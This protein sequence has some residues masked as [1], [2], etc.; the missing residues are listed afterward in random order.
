MAKRYR[1]RNR[2][3]EQTDLK[4]DYQRAL[5]SLT[6]KQRQA[7]ELVVEQEFTVTETMLLLRLSEDA[8]RD[9]LERARIVVSDRMNDYRPPAYEHLSPPPPD[10]RWIQP[11]PDDSFSLAPRCAV[12]GGNLRTARQWVCVTCRRKYGL[13]QRDIFLPPWAAALVLD[14]RNRRNSGLLKNQELVMADLS[15]AE[16]AEAVESGFESGG[17]LD[18]SDTWF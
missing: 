9:R 11:Q 5:L 8:V 17:D 10:S 14:E 15:D 7:W 12:C 4:S 16:R 2:E 1:G 6:E 13:P 3:Y 18:D